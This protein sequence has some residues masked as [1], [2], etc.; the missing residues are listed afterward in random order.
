[1]LGAITQVSA[2]CLQGEEAGSM[3]FDLKPL[4][5]RTEVQFQ[6]R[7]AAKS[8]E[9]LPLPFFEDQARNSFYLARGVC[10]GLREK[11]LEVLTTA[12]KMKKD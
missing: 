6:R 3:R 8:L 12:M 2:F 1:M 5:P 10:W 7:S 4:A 11:S 9:E